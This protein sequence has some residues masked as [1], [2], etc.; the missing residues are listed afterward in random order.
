M[1]ASTQV[2]PIHAKVCQGSNSPLYHLGKQSPKHHLLLTLAM[3][4]TAK[5]A[6]L[7]VLEGETKHGFSCNFGSASV[8]QLP[9]S[10]DSNSLLL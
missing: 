3:G 1:L 7:L 5:A 6:D 4:I 10:S 2:L 9:E 8:E